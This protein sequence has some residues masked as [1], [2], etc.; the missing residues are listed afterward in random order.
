MKTLWCKNQENSSDRIS[1]AWAPLNSNTLKRAKIDDIC[2]VFSKQCLG[3]RR[4][5]AI[6]KTKFLKEFFLSGSD[7]QI[8]TDSIGFGFSSGFGY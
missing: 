5:E 6:E 8:N 2:L 1:H 4:N 7:I 3:K